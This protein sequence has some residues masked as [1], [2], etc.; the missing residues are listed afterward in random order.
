M[1][2]LTWLNDEEARKTSSRVPYRLLEADPA[3]SYGDPNTENML[4]QGDNLDALKALLPY[5][6]GQVKCIY[7]D[8][9]YN[10]QSAFEHYDDNLE[11][12][13]WLSLMYP[14]LEMLR[15][16]LADDGSIWIS[17]DDN[18]AHYIKIVGDEIFGRQHFII[19]ISWRKRDGAPNDR[20]IGSVHEHIL[21]WAKYKHSSSK[22]TLA[23]ES[24][25]LMP[26]TDKANAE[27]KVFTEPDGPDRRGPY[28]KIDTTANGK[29]G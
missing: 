17:I 14:R 4:I 3:L 25:N 2:I 18:E 8:P 12:S 7:I 16:L 9:P 21:V 22:Q 15:D 1:P 24:F 11:H 27:Y 20:K 29:G 5:Y 26:R 13:T 19:D 10:T 23:E 6:A 28:R